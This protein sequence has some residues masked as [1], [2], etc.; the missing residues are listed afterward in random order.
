MEDTKPQQTSS[1]APFFVI[2]TGQAFSLIG[3]SVAQFALVWW[4]T[5]LTGSATVLATATMAAMVPG[6][7][8]GPI[9]G[10][11]VDRW[12]RRMVMIVADGVMALVA[13]WLAYLFWTGTM[14]VWHVYVIMFVRSLGGSFHWPAMQASTSLMVP[15]EHLT[16]VAGLN[17]MMH[18]AMN[19]VSP[20]LGALLMSLLPLHGIMMIDVS[21]AL[22]AISPLFFVH[23]PQPNGGRLP[24]NQA[25]SGG[26]MSIWT[27]VVD[28]LRYVRDW[29]GMQI[30]LGMAMII[31][32]LLTPGGSLLPLL[33]TN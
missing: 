15:K 2:W 23:V 32:F 22:V 28:G 25:A 19:I 18:G 21:T 10:A 11:Y 6:I 3:S 14:Q 1:L 13:L 31:N 27:D 8:L 7:V 9:A 12:N 17:Q 4:L 29:R 33:V 5:R 16:R 26:K 30:L 20:P 24:S